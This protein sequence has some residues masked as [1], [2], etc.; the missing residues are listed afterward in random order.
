M[1]LIPRAVR[2]DNRD[3]DEAFRRQVVDDPTSKSYPTDEPSDGAIERS[4]AFS[5][6]DRE[7]TQTAVSIRAR[8]DGHNSSSR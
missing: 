8:Q 4:K 6:T 2:R 7:G 1:F 5:L 3:A